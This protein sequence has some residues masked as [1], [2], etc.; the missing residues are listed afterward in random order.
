[1]HTGSDGA[2]SGGQNQYVIF[3]QFFDND[4]VFLIVLGPGVIASHNTGNTPDA[5][6]D[7]VVV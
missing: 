7:N 3:D 6:V 5:A 4:N 2:A 1:V